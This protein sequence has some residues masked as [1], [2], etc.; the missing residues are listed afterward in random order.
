MGKGTKGG[1]CEQLGNLRARTKCYE[2][3]NPDTTHLL[4]VSP[5]VLLWY[6][7]RWISC[8]NKLIL[9]VPRIFCLLKD[10]LLACVLVDSYRIWEAWAGENSVVQKT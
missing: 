2:V 8:F 4:C 9:E 7:A 6:V 1:R 5:S 10:L 3:G